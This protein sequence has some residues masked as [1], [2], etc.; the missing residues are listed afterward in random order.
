M[1]EMRSD[2]ARRSNFTTASE[3]AKKDGLGMGMY[4]SMQD[5]LNYHRE[6]QSRKGKRRLPWFTI[7]SVISIVPVFFMG[8]IIPSNNPKAMMKGQPVATT[9]SPEQAVAQS[10]EQSDASE[11]AQISVTIGGRTITRNL[12]IEEI[13][14]MQAMQQTQGGVMPVSSQ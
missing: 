3:Q 5:R 9:S 2:L 8:D 1:V 12:T 7:I 4:D 14:Q 13:R 6:K 11:T 10:I